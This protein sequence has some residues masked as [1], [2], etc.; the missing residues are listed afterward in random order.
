M[1]L[2]AADGT[3]L[4]GLR[5]LCA[6]IRGERKKDFPKNIE[7]ALVLSRVPDSPDD[8]PGRVRERAAAI[9]E[10]ILAWTRPMPWSTTTTGSL[11]TSSRLHRPASQPGGPRIS[12]ARQVMHDGQR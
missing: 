7:V 1:L 3:D 9:A 4:N 8:A 11:R 2:A 10:S 5:L 12:S 6:E